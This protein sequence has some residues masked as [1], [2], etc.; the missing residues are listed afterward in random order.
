MTAEIAV[1]NRLAVA[2]AADSA[3]TIETQAGQKVYNTVNKLFALSKYE[4]IG[5]MIYGSAQ[6]MGLPWETLIKGFRK[7]LGGTSFAHVDDYAERFLK[8][9]TARG[10]FIT[11]EMERAYVR[12]MVTGCFSA[13][14][15]EIDA[16]IKPE[17]ERGP[18][19][20]ERI[21][22][23]VNDRIRKEPEEWRALK[24]LPN[25]DAAFDQEFAVAYS[26]TVAEAIGAVFE[27]LPLTAGSMAHLNDL[28][29][30]L[31]CKD[32]LH[33]KALSGVVVAGFGVEDVVPRL[34]AYE[35]AGL[36]CGR[37]IFKATDCVDVAKQD[38]I[39]IA[40]AQ[41]DVASTFIEGIDPNLKAV[42]NSAFAEFLT[43]QLPPVLMGRDWGAGEARTGEAGRIQEFANGVLAGFRQSLDAYIRVNHV[44]PIITA[45]RALPIDELAAMAESLVSLTSF[46][47]RMSTD[48]ETVGGPIDVAVI[49]KGDGFI[50]IK[51]KHYFRPELNP[52]FVANY[53]RKDP[54]Y[55]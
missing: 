50:W 48:P 54:H 42:L 45:V 52:A 31:F 17:M 23:I 34:L 16:A 38:A 5:I 14:C 27:K 24:N 44:Q 49:S 25:F 26:E 41:R 32:R 6:F 15:D 29:C 35:L 8:F 39:I 20:A 43:R 9:L 21:S 7:G 18:V 1:M 40:F 22:E 10:A 55:E 46:R 4:P 36:V 47:R 2:L 28:A 3:V 53:Y 30:F 37:L 33:S 19:T 12:T 51:R 11:E 13:L